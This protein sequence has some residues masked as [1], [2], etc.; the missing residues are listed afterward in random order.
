MIV[1]EIE[2][3]ARILAPSYTLFPERSEQERMTEAYR[4]YAVA[5][6]A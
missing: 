6:L 1:V 3:I 5:P 4:S 2:R